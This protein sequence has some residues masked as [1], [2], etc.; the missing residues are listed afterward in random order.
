M[1]TANIWEFSII[2]ILP[3]PKK[4]DHSTLYTS[5]HCNITV[6]GSF[7]TKDICKW[8]TCYYI[9]WFGEYM[10]DSFHKI[11][12]FNSCGNGGGRGGAIWEVKNHDQEEKEDYPRLAVQYSRH[13]ALYRVTHKGW[14]CKDDLK[15]FK[16][17]NFKVE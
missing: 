2:Y 6:I 4:Y 7:S 15:I 9:L 5:V 12:S 11:L 8:F 17:N 3:P 14:D 13:F 1:L 16:Y 10:P